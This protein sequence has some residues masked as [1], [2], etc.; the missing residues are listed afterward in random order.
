MRA[1][2]WLPV[3]AAATLQWLV[4]ATAPFLPFVD[5]PQH[6]AQA[7]LLLHLREPAVAPLYEAR[8]V[9]QVNVLALFTLA[10]ALAV[11][12]EAAAVRIVLA[13]YFCGLAFALYRLTRAL[14]TSA[15][16]A[17]A[18][19]LFAI[20]FNLWYGFLSFCLG[21]PILLLLVARWAGSHAAPPTSRRT[22]AVDAFLWWLLSLAHTLV[23]A[24]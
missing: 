17:A 2:P 24:F 16:G 10:P 1:L 18:A 8:L 12:S 19:L 20:Q 4:L 5:L 7:Q 9:P 15:W 22:L 21:M 6:I 3:A 11:L 14:G 13:F 23:F